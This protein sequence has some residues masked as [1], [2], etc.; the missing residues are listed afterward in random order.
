MTFETLSDRRIFV[1]DFGESAVFR[2]PDIGYKT[3]KV[4]FDNE[5]QGIVGESVE[6]ATAEPRLTCV[7][8]DVDK[9]KFGDAVEF[10]GKN[11]KVVL[12]MDNGTGMT[13][14]MLEKQ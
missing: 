11:Y 3:I 13:E 2:G 4:I 7:T 5:Y 14:I 9:A 6:F 12:V 10:R 8:D 1:S